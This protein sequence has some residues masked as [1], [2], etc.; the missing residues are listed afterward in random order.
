MNRGTIFAL[1]A[2]RKLYRKFISERTYDH[3]NWKMVSNKEYANKLIYDLIRTDKPCM[4]ARFGSTELLCLSNYIGVRNKEHIRNI[5]GYIAGDTLPW[6]W[7][8]KV[9]QNMINNAGF[10]P[11]TKQNIEKFCIL[12]LE[13]I[14]YIDILASWLNNECY[15]QEQLKNAKRI[16]LEDLEPFFSQTPWTKALEGKSVLVV[17]PF[18]ETIKKQ[19][20][21]REVLFD[22]Q[23]LPRFDLNVFS[24]VQSLGGKSNKF[25]NWFDALEYM[26]SGISNTKFDICIIGAGAYG[27]PLA[28]YVKRIGKQSIHMGGVTQLLFGIKGRRWEDYLWWPYSNLFNENWVRPGD[29]EKPETAD[30]VE[31]G[32]YW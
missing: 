20:E 18:A 13:D 10:F 21:K 28:A 8:K 15:F 14:A 25:S 3:R 31:G 32:C 2:T 5:K 17:H 16:V 1:K 19:Y 11:I 9:L 27:L 23:I 6:W 12:M 29:N 7:E 4:V 26:K 30:N 22:N 24:A